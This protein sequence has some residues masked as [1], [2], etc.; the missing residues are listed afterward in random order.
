MYPYNIPK[1]R[2]QRVQRGGLYMHMQLPAPS[3]ICLLNLSTHHYVAVQVRWLCFRFIAIALHTH[4]VCVN[5]SEYNV[6]LC[7]ALVVVAQ[8][9]E[10]FFCCV[11]QTFHLTFASTQ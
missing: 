8:F 10:Y 1:S 7:C 3:T 2:A 4:R 9:F 6:C 11:S 5:V